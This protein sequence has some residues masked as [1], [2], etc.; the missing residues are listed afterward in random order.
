MNQ[1]H[2]D[3]SRSIDLARVKALEAVRPVG[4]AEVLR[5]RRLRVVMANN[6]DAVPDEAE[7]AGLT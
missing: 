4:V 6:S 1:S 5:E 2:Y 3:P 7:G